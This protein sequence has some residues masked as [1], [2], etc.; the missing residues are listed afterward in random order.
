[1]FWSAAS[2]PPPHLS[3][4]EKTKVHPTIRRPKRKLGEPSTA[5]EARGYSSLQVTFAEPRSEISARWFMR[6]PQQF[7]RSNDFEFLFNHRNG[8]ILSADH[9]LWRHWRAELTNRRR[10][11]CDNRQDLG[12]VGK[13][14]LSGF[15]QFLSY[16]MHDIRWKAYCLSHLACIRS[17]KLKSPK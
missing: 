7:R 16:A 10:S 12:A 14:R 11:V 13:L 8:R 17:S 15:R 2:H 6:H 4:C 9:A 1:M 3:N 5:Q